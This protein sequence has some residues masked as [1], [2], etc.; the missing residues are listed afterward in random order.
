MVFFTIDGSL[1]EWG[2]GGRLYFLICIF[3]VYPIGLANLRVV[4]SV[5]CVLLFWCYGRSGGGVSTIY[6]VCMRRNLLVG[7]LCV[8]ACGGFVC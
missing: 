8:V 3:V 1:F 2:W 5:L 4:W 7:K 6:I